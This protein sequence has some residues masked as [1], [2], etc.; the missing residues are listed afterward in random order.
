MTYEFVWD[1]LLLLTTRFWRSK[2]SNRGVLVLLGFA[3][4]TG[5][6]RKTRP[7]EKHEV[8]VS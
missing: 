4:W 5:V 3:A 2:L 7:K 6:Y 1:L 8:S